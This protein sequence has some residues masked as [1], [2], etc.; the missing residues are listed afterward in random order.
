MYFRKPNFMDLQET[1]GSLYNSTE[2]AVISADAG[3][4]M[5]GLLALTLQ[6]EGHEPD[7]YCTLFFVTAQLTRA[8]CTYTSC[9]HSVRVLEKCISHDPR[10][11]LELLKLINGGEASVEGL[12]LCGLSCEHVPWSARSVLKEL[13]EDGHASDPCWQ[14]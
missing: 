9:F 11:L 7:L 5:E 14:E 4:R 13:K 3:L 8:L 2:V 12:V 1:D 10:H 6:R